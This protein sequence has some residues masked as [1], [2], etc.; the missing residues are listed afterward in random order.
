MTQ[1]LL[2]GIAHDRPAISFEIA[3]VFDGLRSENDVVAHSGYII[4]RITGIYKRILWPRTI[5][6]PPNGALRSMQNKPC[7]DRLGLAGCHALRQEYC[8]APLSSFGDCL[9]STCI[10][11]R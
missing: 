8:V 3:Q 2:D 7:R 10:H 6:V 11:S 9:Q 5:Q 4:A 1:I